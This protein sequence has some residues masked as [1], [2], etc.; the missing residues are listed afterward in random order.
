RRARWRCTTNRSVPSG[1]ALGA[2]DGT[3]E[4]PDGSDVRSKSRLARYRASRSV[5]ADVVTRAPPR[6]GSPGSGRGELRLP[7]PVGFF[8]LRGDLDDQVLAHRIRLVQRLDGLPGVADR[9]AQRGD[10]DLDR[11]LVGRP[12]RLEVGEA[13]A[14]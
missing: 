12:A 2:P 6:L 1:G 4:R 7:H 14:F 10:D 8:Q 13:G 11:F 9:R 5:L 3:R